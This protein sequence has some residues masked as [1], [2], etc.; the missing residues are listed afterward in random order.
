MDFVYSQWPLGTGSKLCFIGQYLLLPWRPSLTDVTVMGGIDPSQQVCFLFYFLI[1][2]FHQ[3]IVFCHWLSNIINGQH[4]NVNDSS[5]SSI[6]KKQIYQLSA[7]HSHLFGL[8]PVTHYLR[9]ASALLTSLYCCYDFRFV[10]QQLGVS[11]YFCGNV[12]DLLWLWCVFFRLTLGR[13]RLLSLI[14]VV[15]KAGG[16]STVASPLVSWAIQ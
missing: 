3:Q 7:L 14:S 5:K 15:Y 1:Q 9:P 8:Q 12:T 10:I 11:Q 2:A 16:M 6:Y 4:T 13:T